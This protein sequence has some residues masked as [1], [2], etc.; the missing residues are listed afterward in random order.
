MG[1]ENRKSEIGYRKT[2][3]PIA[4]IFDFRFPISDF[5]GAATAAASAPWLVE[6]GPDEAPGIRELVLDFVA[7][8]AE[9]IGDDHRRFLRSRGGDDAPCGFGPLDADQRDLCRSIPV[10]LNGIVLEQL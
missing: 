9:L 10:V 3:T 2:A 7:E 4:P 1:K 8:I 6:A 5:R